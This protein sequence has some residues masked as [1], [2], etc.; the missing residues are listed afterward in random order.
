MAKSLQWEGTSELS[1]CVL[2]IF[3]NVLSRLQ[4]RFGYPAPT[5]HVLLKICPLGGFVFCSSCL[6]GW[7]GWRHPEVAGVVHVCVHDCVV[8]ARPHVAGMLEQSGVG[9]GDA[10]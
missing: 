3:A 4:I 9:D 10:P 7:A 1:P 2:C 6:D 8:C 5:D